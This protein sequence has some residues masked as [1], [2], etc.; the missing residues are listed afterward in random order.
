MSEVSIA[1]AAT[2]D[3]R[4]FRDPD[5]TA[6]GER[7]ARVDF[8]R[9]ATLWFNTGTLC[10]LIGARA[11]DIELY[12]CWGKS[13]GLSRLHATVVIL[14]GVTAIA[15]PIDAVALAVAPDLEREGWQVLAFPGKVETRFIG[16][17]DG[18]IEVRAES[19]VALLYREVAPTEGQNQHLSW[20]WR[21]DETM[22][23]TDLALS[24]RAIAV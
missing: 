12:M 2:V 24:R 7:R 6:S 5:I 19:S 11:H 4:K 8:R 23:P 15:L 14:M 22:P 16:R 20:R 18:T 3:P 21:V 13:V 17:S 10:N 1:R 9:L